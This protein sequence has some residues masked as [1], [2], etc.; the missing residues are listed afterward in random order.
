MFAS[1]ATRR[2]A[3]RDY[4]NEAFE[5]Q[6]F[7]RYAP[8]VAD[9]EPRKVAGACPF[10]GAWTSWVE[11]LPQFYQL[12]TGGHDDSGFAEARRAEIE[13]PRAL[14]GLRS[15][16]AD[17]YAYRAWGRFAG[18][19]ADVLH[20]PCSPTRPESGAG[21]AAAGACARARVCACIMIVI[22]HLASY[23]IA[24]VVSVPRNI[25]TTFFWLGSKTIWP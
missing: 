22:V 14:H 3:Q 24:P 25:G 23:V 21:G 5:R 1:R 2:L 18:A 9:Q 19:Q 17:D 8:G 11:A 20:A 7:G 12:S 13:G 4:R 15:S 6:L 10:H 16:Q